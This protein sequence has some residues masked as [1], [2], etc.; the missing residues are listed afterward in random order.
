M[1]Y[2]NLSVDQLTS[3]TGQSLSPASS[4]A[5]M[6][7]RIINGGMVI[8][9]RNNGASVTPTFSI[10]TVDRWSANISQSSKFS[11]QQNA[12]GITPPVG[13]TNYLGVTSLSAY[14]VSATDY[15]YIQQW[16]EGSNI[17]DLN[18]GTANAKTFT[19]SAWVYSSL[20]GTFGGA[21]QGY[22]GSS[23]RSYPFSYTIPTANTWTYV[24]IT[25]PG[26]TFT[27]SYNSTNG[28]GLAV[29]F[30]L[31][32]GSS[33]SGTS[34]TWAS[35]QYFSATGATSVVGTS[36][37]TF[38]ITGV[39]LEVGTVASSF[40]Y[41][42]Y[43]HELAM[44]QRYFIYLQAGSLFGGVSNGGAGEVFANLPVTM[45]VNPAVTVPSGTLTYNVPWIGNITATANFLDRVSE[46]LIGIAFTGSSGLTTGWPVSS[47]FPVTASA[48]L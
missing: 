25:I 23:F 1:T 18:L 12:G 45:R 44:C 21:I 28:N 24:S 8:D 2:G 5:T 11:V 47:T 46:N 15:F 6:K 48:E 41:R 7:N 20:I 9:Q 38:Y 42:V 14:S 34:G 22:N 19:V 32:T 16:I 13:F 36:G 31:G 39:Q 29:I 4:S 35:G 33:V 26:D 3:S 17:A 40:D 37:A 10:Y 30:S 43:S 27:F